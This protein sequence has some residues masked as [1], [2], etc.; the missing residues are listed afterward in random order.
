MAEEMKAY[1]KPKGDP[2]WIDVEVEIIA[3][4]R[5]KYFT[6]KTAQGEIYADKVWKFSVKRSNKWYTLPN[7]Y[8]ESVEIIS[9]KQAAQEIKLKR[10]RKAGYRVDFEGGNKSYR[11]LSKALRVIASGSKYANLSAHFSYKNGFSSTPLL[12]KE[13]GEWYYYP[14][15]DKVSSKTLNKFCEEN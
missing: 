1:Y 12:V 3:W 13:D 10:K 6:F 11:F 4:D 5:D 7:G 9:K 15:S 2:C 8:M 14:Q